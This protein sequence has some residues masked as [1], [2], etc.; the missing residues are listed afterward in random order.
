MGLLRFILVIS[1][2][3]SHVGYLCIILPNELKYKVLISIILGV[4][5]HF[6]I[7]KKIDS[8]RQKI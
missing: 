6:V 5:I 8:F 4:F 1:V 2:L 3:A 7:E